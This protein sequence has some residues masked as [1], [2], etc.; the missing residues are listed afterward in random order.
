MTLSLSSKAGLLRTVV[1]A[2]V[3]GSLA[4]PSDARSAIAVYQDWSGQVEIRIWACD[5]AGPAQRQVT[6][7]CAPDPGFVVV[8]GGAEVA[9]TDPGGGLLT[10]S[11]PSNDF[12]SWMVASKDHLVPFSHFRRA[13]VIGMRLKTLSGAWM[14]VSAMRSQMYVVRGLSCNEGGCDGVGIPNHAVFLEDSPSFLPGDI[15]LGGGA[16]ALDDRDSFSAWAHAGQLL[17]QSTP[18]VQDPTVPPTGWFGQSKDHGIVDNGWVEVAVIGIRPCPPNFGGCLESRFWSSD[19]V[20]N[21]TGYRSN[22]LGVPDATWAMTS[23]GAVDEWWRGDFVGRMLTDIIPTA[24]SGH[25]GVLAFSKDHSYTDSQGNL[26]V[27]M[28][29]VRKKP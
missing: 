6:T 29:G 3:L 23:V 1:L 24:G 9:N 20:F 14:S 10:G 13:Y 21:A 26:A 22:S 27:F 25:G 16:W 4:S 8:G 5:W 12:T 19:S 7:P 11:T 28:M 15:M 18:F 2:G 17:W